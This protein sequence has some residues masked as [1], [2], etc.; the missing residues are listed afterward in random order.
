MHRS[1]IMPLALAAL[2]TGTVN[3]N[4]EV[5]TVTAREK[6]EAYE[7]LAPRAVPSRRK[8]PGTIANQKR[9]NRRRGGR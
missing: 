1:R 8:S 2:A 9:R 6:A 3:A 7:M 5:I 4:P